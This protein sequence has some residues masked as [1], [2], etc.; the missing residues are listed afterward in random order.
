[1]T[2]PP[3]FV[4][5]DNS[6]KPRDLASTDATDSTASQ[7]LGMVRLLRAATLRVVETIAAWHR[8]VRAAMDE[9]SGGSG[10]GGGAGLP[11]LSREG[12]PGNDSRVATAAAL[13]PVAFKWQDINYLLKL[14][15]DSAGVLAKVS[16]GG[17]TCI[18][19]LKVDTIQSVAQAFRARREVFRECVFNEW[20]KQ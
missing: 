5:S 18:Q 15:D 3:H 14:I 6:I 9:S 17:N 4:F 10:G 13:C 11:P 7:A 20:P 16:R 19:H 8:G 12:A 2:L 1:M